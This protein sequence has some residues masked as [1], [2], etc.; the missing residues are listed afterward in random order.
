M[1]PWAK[2]RRGSGRPALI[3]IAGQYRQWKRMMFLPMMCTSAGHQRV[4]RGHVVGEAGAGDV[5]RQRVEPDVDAVLGI[6]RERDA[7]LAA[8]AA[9]REVAQA[10]AQPAEDL[11]AEVLRLAERRIV[12]VELL[13]PLLVLAQGEEPVLL[14]EPLDLE[15]RV[16][17]TVSVDQLGV[18]LELV[19]ARA[20]P[21]RVHALVDVAR[22]HRPA[23]ISTDARAWSGS[24]VRMKRS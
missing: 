20:V 4:E 16:L 2:T 1:K 17:G 9:D 19:V 21:A 8:G 15:R 6:I 18:G 14:L 13:E 23:T 22:G 3:S 12:A 24:V 7:P 11:V 5:V 10:L